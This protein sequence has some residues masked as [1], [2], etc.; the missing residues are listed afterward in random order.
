MPHRFTLAIAIALQTL[1][2]CPTRAECADAGAASGPGGN[3]ATDHSL[4]FDTNRFTAKTLTFGGRHIAYRAYE[5]IV[6]A[7]HPVD[8]RYEQL[9]FYA[10]VEYF[11]GKSV[12]GYTAGTAPIFF[13]NSVGG[14]MPGL[15]ASAERS[16]APG[17]FRGPGM[18]PGGGPGPANRP[19]AIAQALA[20]GLVV[21]APG[22]RGRTLREADGTYTG[23][24]PA[25]IVDLKAAVRYLRLNDQLM[26]GD[27]E[28]IVSNGTSAGG[29]LSALLGATGNSPDF[30]PYLQV[31]GAAKGRDD[32][33]AASCYCPITDLDHADAA[34]EWL[35]N[36]INN[37]RGRGGGSRALSP[38]QLTRSDQLKRLYPPYLN[39]MNLKGPDGAT[40]VLDADGKG[41]FRDYVKSLVL[42]SAQAALQNEQ[43]LTTLPWIT[44]QDGKVADLDFAD[45]LAAITRMKTPPAF[46][47]LDLSTPENNL[48]G[49]A[50]LDSQHFTE[51]GKEHSTDHT[52]AEAAVVRMMNPLDYLGAP[53]VATARYWRIRHGT[54]DRDTSLAVPVVLATKLRN[55][56]SNVDF[57]LPWAQGHGGDYDLDELFGWVDQICR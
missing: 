16:G 2:G 20:R 15:P 24:A 30:Q 28:K 1:L 14:Y 12:G 45:Y 56:G 43:D 54:A 38:E 22:A 5:G 7:A 53:G 23:K 19:N 41:S 25:C 18:P 39:S 47:A 33:F 44:R 36:G 37:Y 46:D 31:I 35:F 9:N 3:S 52:M 10:P 49:T 42:A 55:R 34:Y 50:T 21:A 13:P 4:R 32:I 8:A 11:E 40:L 51:F 6:Y 26:P 57:A 29:A 17:G 27:A 48:F